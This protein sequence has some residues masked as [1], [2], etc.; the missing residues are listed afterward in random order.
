M[1]VYYRPNTCFFRK[2]DTKMIIPAD[3]DSHDNV[4]SVINL[5]DLFNY[6]VQP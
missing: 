3:L 2:T 1:I 4:I 5:S 6:I